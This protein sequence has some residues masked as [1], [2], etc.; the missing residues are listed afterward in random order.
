MIELA[1]HCKEACFDAVQTLA[2]RQLREGESKG[3][4]PRKKSTEFMIAVITIHAFPKLVG[5]KVIHQLREYRSASIHTHCEGHASNRLR[6]RSQASKGRK[7][8]EKFQIEKS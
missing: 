3:T 6:T 7:Q 4:D 2:I 5:R 1:A 8:S